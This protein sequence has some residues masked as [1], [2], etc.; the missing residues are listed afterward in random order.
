ML[1]EP[2]LAELAHTGRP[3]DALPGLL[4]HAAGDRAR[5]AV[6]AATRASRYAA[7]SVLAGQLREVLRAPDA[8]VTARKEAVRLA[9][10]R[11]PVPGAPRSSRRRTAAPA[12]TVTSARPA[13]PSRAVS[14]P[15]NPSGKY[16]TTPPAPS[17]YRAPPSCASPRSTCPSRTGP[18]T[19]AWSGSSP[20]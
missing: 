16:W 11:L 9:A 15:G 19:P 20:P 6:Y 10:A 13:S 1:A 17:P 2:V 7:P 18:G 4:A 3:A 8:K 14:S 5:T 12:H